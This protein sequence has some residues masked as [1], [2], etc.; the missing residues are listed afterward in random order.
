MTE[1]RDLTAD[2]ARLPLMLTELRLPSIARLWPDFTRRADEEGW[3]AARL[4]AALAEI[5]LADR[6]R[7]RIER[8]LA[9]AKLPAGKTLASFDF[10]AVPTL[11]KAHVTALAAGDGWIDKGANLLAF[12]PPGSYARFWVMRADQAARVSASRSVTPLV[13]VTPSTTRGNWFAPFRRR[14]VLAAA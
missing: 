4:L 5:E 1:T 11:S 10:T 13:N 7:R 3:P 2:T 8:H 6:A 14:H 9:E 12:G